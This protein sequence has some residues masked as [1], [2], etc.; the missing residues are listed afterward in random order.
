MNGFREYCKFKTEFENN[1]ENT[2]I[3]KK[4]TIISTNICKFTSI[5]L[6]SKT[7][8]KVEKPKEAKNSNKQHLK[9]GN[10]K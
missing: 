2:Y 4:S 9:V 5:L 3:F 10:F 8:H 6:L 1:F 7:T